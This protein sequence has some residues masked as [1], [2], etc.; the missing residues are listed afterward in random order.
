MSNWEPTRGTWHNDG[1]DAHDA[2]WISALRYAE[3]QYERAGTVWNYTVGRTK[4][5][6][7]YITFVRNVMQILIDEAHYSDDVVLGLC[8]LA[9]VEEMTGC[10]PEDIRRVC[11]H[12]LS[13]E[14]TCFPKKGTTDRIEYY[15]NVFGDGHTDTA[16]V[17]LL[18]ELLFILRTETCPFTDWEED[19]RYYL[20]IKA[21]IDT[22]LIKQSNGTVCLLCNKI[23]EQLDANQDTSRNINKTPEELYAGRND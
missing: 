11:S 20:A 10:S 22:Y 17:V 1:Y 13:D 18:A 14:L 4:T 3:T 7:P 15:A 2:E 5:A 19:V 16:M 8:A 6:M 12:E 23:K 21:L 9:R